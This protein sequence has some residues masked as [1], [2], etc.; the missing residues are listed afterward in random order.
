VLRKQSNPRDTSA[1]D[2]EQAIDTNRLFVSLT[3]SA[4]RCEDLDRILLL[5]RD[6]IVNECGFDRAGVFSYDA[7]TEIMQ[8]AWGTDQQGQ[9]EVISD[10][11][12][13]VPCPTAKDFHGESALSRSF[14]LER[15]DFQD[16]GPHG[17]VDTD[18]A[19]NH[20]TVF[21]R[22]SNELVGCITIDNLLT[23]RPVT[24][25]HIVALI[26]FA[27][28]AALVVSNAKMRSER[29]SAIRQQRR[30]MEISL[31]I[32]SNDDPD[33][34]LKMA[35]NAIMEIGLLDRVALWV[36]RDFTAYGT[37]G[38][39]EGGN[40][41]DEH[42]MSFPIEPGG[43][44][45]KSFDHPDHPFTIDTVMLKD[46]NDGHPIEVSHAFLP[47]RV[48]DEV[49]GII[50]ID[51]LLTLRK[52][53]PAML[54]PAVAIADQ[55]A[56]AVQKSRLLAHSEAVVR[57]QKL[58]MEIAVA[59][60]GNV[61]TDKLF[62][63]V[64]DAI[65]ETG[66]VDRVGVFLVEGGDA[67]GTWGTDQ[68]GE[69]RDEHE[70]RF[71]LKDFSLKYPKCLIGDAPYELDDTHSVKFR[72]GTI[73]TDIP[74]GVIPLRADNEL[75]GIVVADTLLTR[76]KLTS[77]NLDLILPLVR[78][79]AVVVQ[80]TRLLNAARQEIEKR[81]QA[82]E[83]LLEQAKDLIEARDQALAGAR[84]KSE[85]LANMS[86]EIR[87]PMNGVI[88]M[89]S[90][91]METHLTAEQIEYAMGMQKSADALLA[92]IDDILSISQLEAGMLRLNRTDFNLRHCITDLTQARSAQMRGGPVILTSRLPD[93]FPDWLVGDADRVRQMVGNLVSNAVKFTR[94][95]EIQIL[96]SCVSETDKQ[97]TIR[98]EV[99]DTGIGIAK[100][101]Q[102]EV[103]ESF[104]QADGSS[105]R[106]H[107]G[108]GLGLTIARQIAQ[109]MGGTI[110][111]ESELGKGTTIWL[112]IP[113]EKQISHQALAAN[114]AS[115][116]PP[117]AEKAET[118][119]GIK[120]LLAEDNAVNA[121]LAMKKLE[122]WGCTCISVENGIEALS[123]L[124]NGEFD[125]ILMDISMPEM[126][127]IQ[128]TQELRRREGK[129]GAHTPIIALTAHALEGDRERCLASGMD[130][131][132]PKPVNFNDLLSKLQLWGCRQN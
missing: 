61:D 75:V 80:K 26:P 14:S 92:I 81:R 105:T 37:W 88:G 113:F 23:N 129:T 11:R 56:V 59:V 12:F 30:L 100:N 87:T 38:T 66:V 22:T 76:R 77:E 53:T 13:Q 21:L 47:L 95:G 43:K 103:F 127:G 50:T 98:L 116:K 114:P 82:E 52:I 17:G 130:D 4:T 64:R 46:P 108:T 124:E 118:H 96:A 39:D 48:D 85:F 62:R 128:T 90:I 36:V 71:S 73:H 65:L 69:P 120:V 104:T 6:L 70:T 123:E 115:V 112:E 45:F 126:D 42:G 9:P 109:L 63:M 19:F 7:V 72:D 35:R 16:V 54:V 20:A 51:M 78:Q 68:F 49:I 132:L 8:G 83:L 2:I 107:G 110:G 57:Q 93:R 117:A 33:M 111:M 29:V 41:K 44:Y 18:H 24:E 25:R 28:H 58:L 67:L 55:A 79:A 99:R 32:T 10:Q 122:G 91:L 94:E 102:A 97:A 101:R 3:G 119:L 121:F 89:A 131:Y 31:A 74:F 40:L 15:Y 86:H 1:E 125:L 60:A 27:E 5:I 106:K 84:A 34:V